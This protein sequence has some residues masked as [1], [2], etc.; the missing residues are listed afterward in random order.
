MI[1]EQMAFP[2]VV[3]MILLAALV[4]APATARVNIDTL[5]PGDTVYVGEENLVFGPAFGPEPITRLVHFSNPQ[6]GQ[7]DR[8]IVVSSPLGLTRSD[9]GT[10]T[11]MY[12][13]F[14]Q[15]AN[16]TVPANAAGYVFIVVPSVALDIV[17]NASPMDSVDGKSVYQDA[18]LDFKVQNNLSGFSGV[19]G[20]PTMNI[21]IV[22]P[23][24]DRMATF[25]GVNLNGIPADGTTV[26]LGGIDL[27]DVPVGF[28]TAIAKWDQT[29]DFYGKRFDSNSVTF[30]VLSEPV[31]ITSN[32]D[33]VVRGNSFTVTISGGANKNYRLYIKE[34]AD[35][36]PGAYPVVAS[37]QIGIT[38]ITSPTDATIKTTAGGTRTVQ[39]NTDQST[40]DYVFTICVEDPVNPGIR[41]EVRVRVE[42]GS[43]TITTSGIGVYYIGEEITFSGINT[44]NDAT[45]LF[46]T[47]ANL[48][49][50][51]V[52]LQNVAAP[53]E[54]GN[55]I[56]FTCVNVMADDAWSYKWNTD[57]GLDAG[58]YTIYAVSR[59]MDKSDLSSAEYATIS[60]TLWA[61][62]PDPTSEYISVAKW[63]EK[64][65]KKDGGFDRPAGIAVDAT[66]NIYVADSWN[67]RIQKF[68][69]SGSFLAKWGKWGTDDGQFQFPVDVAVDDAGYVYVLDEL[70]HR[71]QKFDGFGNFIMTWGSEGSG[72]SEF[73]SPRGIT[74]NNT[75]GDI[76]VADTYNCRIQKFNS[77]GN[78]LA[79]W[80][81]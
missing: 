28:Y 13:A 14:N 70:N 77:S 34:I 19:A 68:D 29:A 57:M 76:Y 48:P 8:R 72:D 59:P 17:L 26:C 78:F 43:V 81:S 56:N 73:K 10:T 24:G 62:L 46:L 12:Y 22:L 15:S 80:G 16:E 42:R 6:S 63:G 1:S 65:Y 51:G 20:A 61:S 40:A 52:S 5:E 36:P 64:A 55:P 75:T 79:A 44:A 9:F 35:V 23:S 50:N 11:G 18:V 7:I 45:Y 25:G 66:G 47:G 32:K 31:A 33:S 41:G 58:S 2:M 21:E 39:F 67:H 53:V 71:V 38:N 3:T 74:V 49:A 60:I 37:G 30:E 27:M 69:S 4:V 54:S